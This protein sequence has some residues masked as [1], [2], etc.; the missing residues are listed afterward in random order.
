[1]AVGRVS[2]ASEGCLYSNRHEESP[3]ENGA[4]PM[5]PDDGES[6]PDR[7]P[8]LHARVSQTS[9]RYLRL[10]PWPRRGR[11]TPNCCM[12]SRA[13]RRFLPAAADSLRKGSGFEHVPQLPIARLLLQIVV[14]NP[15]N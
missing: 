11:E 6:N 2:S 8:E 9:R 12:T 10:R 15:N 14:V 4:L 7:I 1:M 13:C 3:S 5:V